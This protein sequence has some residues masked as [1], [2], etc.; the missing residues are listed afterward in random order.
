MVV[1]QP[2][3][4]LRGQERHVTRQDEDRA[5]AA[6]EA[7]LLDG[8]AAPEPLALHDRAHVGSG[9]G[10]NVVGVRSHDQDDPI[11]KG[12]SGAEGV[13][14]QGAA[15]QGV[16]HLGLPRAHAL[17]LAGGKNDSGHLAHRV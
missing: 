11:G 7:R 5:V 17:A 1:D 12:S 3:D 15:A 6:F 9:H 4:R 8:V 14:D 13:G 10:H 2:L 16:E